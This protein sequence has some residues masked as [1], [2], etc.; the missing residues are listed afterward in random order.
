MYPHT[1]DAARRC[2]AN[3]ARFGAG[4]GAGA[5]CQRAVPALVG[6]G[7]AAALI[8][9]E[10]RKTMIVSIRNVGSTT[11]IVF[12]DW[13]NTWHSTAENIERAVYIKHGY[14]LLGSNHPTSTLS[15]G[16]LM[17]MRR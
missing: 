14:D 1:E 11:F 8:V 16:D 6:A 17:I 10:T 7:T 3:K 13:N 2:R 4:V 15:I 9:P 12:P 5:F